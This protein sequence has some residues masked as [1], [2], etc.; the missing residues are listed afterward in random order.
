MIEIYLGIAQW[1]T[2]PD[3]L[4]SLGQGMPHCQDT[5]PQCRHPI[6]NVSERSKRPIKCHLNE[7]RGTS[8]GN[9]PQMMMASTWM[10]L[11]HHGCMNWQYEFSG[12]IMCLTCDDLKMSLAW[13]SAAIASSPNGRCSAM[14]GFL[15]ISHNSARIPWLIMFAIKPSISRCITS[16]HRTIFA[17]WV[18]LWNPLLG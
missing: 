18:W 3:S 11:T 15:W 14:L 17:W 10:C 7:L 12:H 2:T 5:G 16:P 1:R 8:G 13:R 6:V 9:H 4:D